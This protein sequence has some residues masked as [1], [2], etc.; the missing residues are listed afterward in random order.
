MASSKRYYIL[1]FLSFLFAEIYAQTAPNTYLIFFTDKNNS[2]YSVSDPSQYLTQRAITRRNKQNISI[3]LND[4]P[5]NPQYIDSVET[6][7]G[8]TVLCDSKWLNTLTIMVTDTNVLQPI[9]NLGF[10]KQVRKTMAVPNKIKHPSKCE[11]QTRANIYISLKDIYGYTY[12]QVSMMNGNFLHDLGYNGEGIHVAVMD[13]G[14]FDAENMAVF[15]QARTEGRIHQEYDFVQ[16]EQ[17]VYNTGASHGTL[18]LSCMAGDIANEYK[19]TATEAD[20]FLFVTEND[21][22]EYIVEE[23]YWIAA[24]EWADSIGADIINT[25]LGY[26][27]F[28]DSLQDHTYNDMDGNT[29][30]ISIA[31]DIAVSKGMISVN[32]A[33]NSGNSPWYYISAPADAD[34]VL[35]VGAVGPDRVYASF[36]SKGPSSDGRVK[37]NVAAQ[38][39]QP[40]VGFPG[41]GIYPANGTSFSSP[42]MAGMVACLWQAHPERT[43]M[44]IKT[45]IE[46]SASQYENPDDFI[47]Y[48]IPDFF[49][50]HL[51]LKG[52]DVMAAQSTFLVNIMNNPFQDICYAGIYAA[53]AQELT[54]TLTDAN[55]KLVSTKKESMAAGEYRNFQITGDL[56]I[57]HSGIYFLRIE[58]NRYAYTAK[59][60]KIP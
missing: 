2:P 59:L 44:E 43:N 29:T 31:A 23:D 55:G 48:G 15:N 10:V 24:A 8:V 46:M 50:A 20:Y 7:T 57:I 9:R 47:G 13:A 33:G 45:A 16:R 40:Y 32:S 6:F 30:R 27:T 22:S 25:S 58:S 42:I 5:V 41:G 34:S 4:L 19:G 56:N 52:Y 17:D 35:T 11:N 18:V 36:S 54:F 60:V 12:N 21:T 53:S 37:P 1:F 28:D 26:T 39:F 38:G 3:K 14:Y 49:K 51:I